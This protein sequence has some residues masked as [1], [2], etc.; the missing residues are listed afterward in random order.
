MGHF[1]FTSNYF[2]CPA[3]I[4][5]AACDGVDH[6]FVP[7]FLNSRV[8]ICFSGSI[9]HHQGIQDS[10]QFNKLN[11]LCFLSRLSALPE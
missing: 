11:C 8:V 5:N 3:F 4:A 1:E 9:L 2:T 10:G 7:D 6:N